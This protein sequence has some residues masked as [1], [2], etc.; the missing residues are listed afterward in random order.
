MIIYFFDPKIILGWR[1]KQRNTSVTC[2]GVWDIFV[3]FYIL[4]NFLT[5]FVW[6]NYHNITSKDST[7]YQLTRRTLMISQKLFLFDFTKLNLK[8]FQSPSSSLML[9]A[10]L[11]MRSDE[12]YQL[13]WTMSIPSNKK[14]HMHVL[15][16]RAC[17]ARAPS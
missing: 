9:R 1:N 8:Y 16:I 14:S 13:P 11:M 12:Q 6:N 7:W 10:P 15:E 5:I 2:V 4:R 3:L 17:A